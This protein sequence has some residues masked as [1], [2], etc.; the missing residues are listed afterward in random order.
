VRARGRAPPRR[1]SSRAPAAAAT[2]PGPAP[3]ARPAPPR[4]RNF[5]DVAWCRAPLV[6]WQYCSPR[7]VTLE[8]L[9]GVK[10]TDAARLREAGVPLALV[11]QRAT[12]AYLVQVRGP[13][14]GRRCCCRRPA[15]ACRTTA[16]H[17][18]PT[19]TPTPHPP[20]PAAQ[21]LRHGFFHADPHPG[22]LA[23]DPAGALIYYGEDA[24]P[25]RPPCRHQ[26]VAQ[27]RSLTH[28]P[29][30]RAPRPA[31]RPAPPQTLA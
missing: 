6:Y 24:Q 7:V 23:V 25:A 18:H 1:V 5:R 17:S 10:I 11:A 28:Q 30:P 15:P 12:E 16:P 14:C 21:V 26:L 3:L 31:P 8:Y 22:N 13:S 4:R 29:V 19:P 9:P 2:R 20:P 27:Q